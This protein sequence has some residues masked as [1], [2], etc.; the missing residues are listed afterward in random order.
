[1]PS[2]LRLDIAEYRR[3]VDIKTAYV[4][5][6]DSF[7][8]KISPGFFDNPKIGMPSTNGMMVLLSS[9]TG[10]AQALLLDS[11]LTNVRTAAAGAVAANYLARKDA[12]VAAVL[13]AGVQARLQ[14]GALTLVRRIREARAWARDVGAAQTVAQELS[15]QLGYSMM[16]CAQPVKAVEGSDVIITTTP[17]DQPILKAA[18]GLR[19]SNT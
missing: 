16:A 13:G 8:I 2:I 14:L 6:L 1:M 7:A 18:W 12:S 4:P 5:G 9:K 10:L 3:E 17:A 11:Y 15:M 19:L